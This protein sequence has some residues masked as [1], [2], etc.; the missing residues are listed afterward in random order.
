MYCRRRLSV[1]SVAQLLV[2]SL[3]FI[4]AA[5]AHI[6]LARAYFPT[7]PPHALL[8]SEAFCSG[9]IEASSWEPR[10][11]NATA[12]KDIPSTSELAAF[13]AEPLNFS[14]GPPNADF[15]RVDGNYSGTTDMIIRWAACKWGMDENVLRAQAFWESTWTSTA[16]GDFSTE[17][18]SCAA[19]AW[20]GWQPQDY[21][22]ESY[23]ITQMKV[24][25]YNAWP[26]AWT[27]TAFNLDFRAAYWR[28]CMNGDVLYYYWN[29]PSG[30]YP[31]YS[32]SGATSPMQWGCVGSWYSGEWYDAA[33]LNYIADIE[34]LYATR[35]WRNLPAFNSPALSIITPAPNQIISG[36]FNI[37]I[38][39]NQTNPKACYACLSLDG[40]HQT[41]TPAN[42][43]WPW[44]T[45]ENVLNGVH[46]VQ[47]DA[48]TCSG[49]GPNYH[50]GIDVTV[51]N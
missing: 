43:P 36:L 18:A 37:S 12:N 28:A 10:P 2:A 6:R 17:Q 42:G 51:A 31:A 40:V 20:N 47:V 33:A 4:A 25:S 15:V 39:L 29:V 45:T 46:S 50:A 1:H 8:P 9:Q 21:C 16:V 26:M 27:S 32:A 24:D 41:C 22:W 19:G 48:Y 44:N 38:H 49:E 11:E 34:N 13:H 35:P 5:S 23:G 7:L 14:D 30:G 3:A